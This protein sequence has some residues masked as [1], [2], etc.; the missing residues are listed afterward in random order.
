V[1]IL[2]ILEGLRV[3]VPIDDGDSADSSVQST[4]TSNRGWWAPLTFL[5]RELGI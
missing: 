3:H 5:R 2:S 4:L 1:E